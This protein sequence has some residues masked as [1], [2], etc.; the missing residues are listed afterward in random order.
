[1]AY[2][3]VEIPKGQDGGLTRQEINRLSEKMDMDISAGNYEVILS[4]LGDEVEVYRQLIRLRKIIDDTRNPI[5]IDDVSLLGEQLERFHAYNEIG[6]ILMSYLL[7]WRAIKIT[8][9]IPGPSFSPDKLKGLGRLI[10]YPKM[11]SLEYEGL[12]KA[13]LYT[14]F[15]SEVK[16]ALTRCLDP[17]ASRPFDV[18]EWSLFNINP[19]FYHIITNIDYK[20]AGDV[21]MII[22]IWA[23]GKEAQYFIRNIHHYYHVKPKGAAEIKTMP[24][25]EIFQELGR[26]FYYGSREDLINRALSIEPIRAFCPLTKSL[27]NISSNRDALSGDTIEESFDEGLP[28]I[29]LNIDDT[30][31]TLILE[32]AIHCWRSTKEIVLP[33]DINFSIPQDI[34]DEIKLLSK[35][36]PIKECIEVVSLIEELSRKEEAVDAENKD[37][38]ARVKSLKEEDRNNFRDLLRK[39]FEAAMYLRGWDGTPNRYP[40]SSSQTRPKWDVQERAT[41]HLIEASKLLEYPEVDAIFELL[42]KYEYRGGEFKRSMYGSKLSRYFGKVIKGDE[43]IRVASKILCNTSSYYLELLFREKIDGYNHNNIE[44]IW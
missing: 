35:C 25:G 16:L 5:A 15:S 22:P 1:M 37:L 34:V 19:I 21:G 40:L 30:Y 27:L 13:Y 18:S 11:S 9:L 7:S 33:H 10:R 3:S 26:Y 32:E 12:I 17:T 41:E 36:Y 39:I 31:H 28:M 43:C 20:M 29:M 38:V 42:Y 24:D 8:P 44:E 6:D 4:I 23:K 2:V 14:D